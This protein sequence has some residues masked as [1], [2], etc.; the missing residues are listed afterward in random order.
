MTPAR[1]AVAARIDQILGS[2]MGSHVPSGADIVEALTSDPE[3]RTD[4]LAETLAGAIRQGHR[5]G[6]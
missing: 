1:E 5:L 6:R 2:P 4:L 3:A